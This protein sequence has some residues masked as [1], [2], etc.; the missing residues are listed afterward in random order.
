[1]PLNCWTVSG[2][3]GFTSAE[4]ALDAALDI[5]DTPVVLSRCQLVTAG[6][7]RRRSFSRREASLANV[8]P[9]RCERLVDPGQASV[10]V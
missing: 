1:M 9:P 6:A 10:P 3:F 8:A 7:L 2:L 5:R 4:A